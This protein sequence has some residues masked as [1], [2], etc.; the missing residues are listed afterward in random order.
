MTKRAIAKRR[1]LFDRVASSLLIVIVVGYII[2]H[3]YGFA[4]FL[5]HL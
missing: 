2:F 5:G 3:L 1:M 4:T